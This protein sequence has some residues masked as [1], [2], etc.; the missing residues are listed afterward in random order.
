MYELSLGP[1]INICNR[2]LLMLSLSAAARRFIARR[3]KTTG[4]V[5]DCGL[6]KALRKL[7]ESQGAQRS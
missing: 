7:Q 4:R 3:K 2:V 5:A 6:K 1:A